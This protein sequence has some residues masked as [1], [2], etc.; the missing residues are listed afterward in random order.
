MSGV[1]GTVVFDLFTLV[2]SAFAIGGAIFLITIAQGAWNMNIQYYLVDIIE[3]ALA[4]HLP[5]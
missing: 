3:I 1:G 2:H 4:Q 5:V